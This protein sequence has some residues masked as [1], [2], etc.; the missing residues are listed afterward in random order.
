MYE[1][2]EKSIVNQI[3]SNK[4]NNYLYQHF[5]HLKFRFLENCLLVYEFN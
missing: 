5:F 2:I 1:T 3:I 4:N